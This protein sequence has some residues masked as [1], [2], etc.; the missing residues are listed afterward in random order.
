MSNRKFEMQ[1]WLSNHGIAY[2]ASDLKV[3]LMAK[4]RDAKP[5]KQLET[6]AIA[7]K[8]IHRVLVAHPE[9][10]P[11]ELAWSVRA[12]LPNTKMFTLN[13]IEKLAPRGYQSSNTTDVENIQ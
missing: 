7:E 6:D 3:D 12:M 2:E 4:I 10:N 1:A 5:T 9:L 8:F 13:E 11:I